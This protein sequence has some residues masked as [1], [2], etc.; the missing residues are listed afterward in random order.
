MNRIDVFIIDC[1]KLC[2]PALCVFDTIIEFEFTAVCR[3]FEFK[4]KQRHFYWFI[5]LVPFLHVVVHVH[6]CDLSK[7]ATMT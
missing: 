7:F 4:R 2:S 1:Q 5:S 6:D 3:H